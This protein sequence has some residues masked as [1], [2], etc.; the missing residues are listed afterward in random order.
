MDIQLDCHCVMS[1]TI[2]RATNYGIVSVVYC[3]T[4]AKSG[5]QLP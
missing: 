5:P 4:G 1:E 3:P 2:G